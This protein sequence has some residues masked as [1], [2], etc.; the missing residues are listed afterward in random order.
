MSH[1]TQHPAPATKQSP[2]DQADQATA[3]ALPHNAFEDS[4]LSTAEARLLL[5]MSEGNS[6]KAIARRLNKSEF[7][8][9]N[10]L[11]S[12]FRKIGVSNRVEAASWLQRINRPTA[13]D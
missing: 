12:A 1:I 9:R 7:T 4:G 13:S 8:V 2:A 10:Q 3:F 6:N 5:A 11:S